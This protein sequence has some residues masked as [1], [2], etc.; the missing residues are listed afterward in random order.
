MFYLIYQRD[1]DM[2]NTIVILLPVLSCSGLEL[3]GLR[4]AQELI[5]RGYEPVVAVPKDSALDKQCKDRNLKTFYVSAVHKY[6]L[7]SF[8]DCIDILKKIEPSKIVIF[9][10]QMIYP[11]HFARIITSIHAEIYMFYRIGVGNSVRKDPLHRFLFKQVKAIIPNAGYV[12]DKMK[13]LWGVDKDKVVC[14]KSGV[15]VN[16][17]CPST[18]TRDKFR[19]D[20]GFSNDDFIIGASGRIE[21]VKGSE[22][23]IRALFD[24]SDSPGHMKE[25]IHLVFVGK[26]SK[27]GY[28]D[29]LKQ[30]SAELNASN[31][32]HFLPFRNDI[33]NYYPG[34]DLFA[35]AVNCNEC[36]AY[37]VLEAMTCGIPVLVPNSGGLIE[38]FTDGVE[39]RFFEHKNID[40]LRERFAQ[41]IAMP[42]HDL[43]KMGDSAREHVLKTSDWNKMIEKYFSIMSL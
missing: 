23:L 36:Y 21:P 28:I 1:I 4:F 7:K 17:Y 15:D 37:T 34:L 29:Y 31:K 2:K 25:N 11:V 27:I 39:G 26:E 43:K 41:I 8:K 38:M 16:K 30:L 6:S 32:V 22:N 18:K 12:A 40:S 13:R 42:A 19:A 3:F 20:F 35:F 10:S 5:K 14:I 9:R 33:E 24:G